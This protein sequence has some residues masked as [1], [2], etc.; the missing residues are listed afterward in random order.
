MS[1]SV[2]RPV[3]AV[4]ALGLGWS[5]V[6]AAPDPSSVR[7]GLHLGLEHFRWEELG[8]SPANRQLLEE[9]GPRVTAAVTVD[10]LERISE[11]GL[12]AFKLRGSY[13][14]VD[15][16]GETQDG[17]PLQTESEYLAAGAEAR[18]GFRFPLRWSSLAIDPMVGAGVD[19]WSRDI[20][21]GTDE[22]GRRVGGL[23]ETYRVIYAK[24]G[25]GLTELNHDEWT[26]RLEAG[27]KY[28]LDIHEEVSAYSASLEPG[29]DV[30]LYAQYQV[31]R[32]TETAKYALTVYYETY[33]FESSPLVQTGK[34]LDGDGNNDI[35]RQ[36]Q[37]DMDRIGVRLGWFL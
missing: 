36:P 13:G 10:N 21:G 23:E 14:Q 11:G 17:V 5:T 12:F 15:Y 22:I 34:D 25:L 7:T 30:S 29:R 35:I 18:T 27:G 33:R 6:Q 28:P 4:F 32:T 24:A 16:D 2:I 37:S 20:Q 26:G 1:P 19:W 3:W 31:T 9:T 8:A